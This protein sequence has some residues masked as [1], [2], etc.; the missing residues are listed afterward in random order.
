MTVS[1]NTG[2]PASGPATAGAA[3]EPT[4]NVRP[5][6]ITGVILVNLGINVAFFAP[7]QVLL[8]QQSQAFDP[9]NKEA[10][11]ALATGS[12]AAVSLIAN[13]LFGALSD[14]TVSRFGRR[15]PWIAAGAILGFAALLG[16]SGAPNIA[17]MVLLWCC[18]QAGCN[19]AYAALFAAIPD[20]V[21]RLQRGQVG[22]LA[23]MGQT[24]GIVCGAVIGAIAGGFVVGYL[25]CAAALLVSV[26][27]YL[28]HSQ[29]EPLDRTERPPFSLPAFARSFWI[30]PRR[31]PDFGWAWLTRFLVNLGTNI[32]TLYLFFFLQDA[33]GHP[34]PE[35]GVLVLTGIYAAMVMVTAVIGGPLSDRAGKRKPFVIGSSVIIATAALI[36]ATFQTFP[37]A[38]VGAAVL[39]IGYGAYL[40]VDFALLTEVLPSGLSR[41]KDL[42]VIN[43]AN[44]LPQ[45]AAPVLAAF[46]VT[47]YDYEILFVISAVIGLLGAVFVVKIKGVA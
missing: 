13:P 30:S 37:A 32:I 4:I 47:R 27:P 22:G 36:M 26:I 43:I 23:A 29:D 31:Y 19:A 40:A 44:S 18:V 7:L 39:G 34:E 46:I 17:V 12:G 38:I 42:G 20:R 15:V 8:A 11:L 2:T 3:A 33:V 10:V 25:I 28:L 35:V 41:G 16:L 5:R 21:P 45:V 9:V 1:D 6:W 24:L 14:R